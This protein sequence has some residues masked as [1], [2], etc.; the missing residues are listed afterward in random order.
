MTVKLRGQAATLIAQ[1]Y[2]FP[3]GPLVDVTPDEMT[4]TRIVDGVQVF[5]TPTWTHV[6]L[7]TYSAIWPI[8]VGSSLGDYLVE[9]IADE[10]TATET[11]SVVEASGSMGT[12]P[13]DVLPVTWVAGCLDT[14]S[15]D[16]TGAAVQAASELI[17]TLSGRRFGLCTQ[18]LRPCRRECQGMPWPA[19]S[20]TWP[21]VWA[22]QT[23]PLPFWWNGQW[24][25]LTCGGCASDCSCSSVEEVVLPGGVYQ[26]LQ[27]LIDGAELSPSSYRLDDNRIVVRTDGGTWPLCNDLSK[28]DT[29]VG[30]YSITAQW[31]EPLPEI[32]KI[33]VGELACEFGKYL[34]GAACDL[35]ESV[36]SLSRQGVSLTFADPNEVLDK[37]RLGLHFVDMFLSAYNP[38]GLRARSQVYSVDGP[39]PRR[40]GSV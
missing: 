21:N 29:E 31:G 28:N 12:S 2:A 32:G 11:I 27:V 3:G 19:G 22:G 23:Y 38:G 37:G 33:A 24:L 34:S 25:N 7:G 18:V 39:N 13:C 35:P 8:N 14:L 26:V 17:W 10:G 9:F 15:P 40:A 30:T 6:G 20:G 5:S 16:V 36:T 1:F 4:V